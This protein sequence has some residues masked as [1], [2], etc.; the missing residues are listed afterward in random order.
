MP[1]AKVTGGGPG[2]ACYSPYRLEQGEKRMVQRDGH[3][4]VVRVTQEVR[5]RLKHGTKHICYVGNIKLERY[6][7]VWPF[8]GSSRVETSFLFNVLKLTMVLL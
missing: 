3:F 4:P 8:K 6:K 2:R 5:E 7:Q 1:V